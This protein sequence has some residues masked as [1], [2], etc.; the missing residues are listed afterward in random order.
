MHIIEL[1]EKQFKNYSIIHSRKNIYQTVN[2]AKMQEKYGFSHLFLG[3]VD[4][5]DNVVAA[6]LILENVINKKFKY[7]IVPAGYLIDFNDLALVKIFTDLLK[8]YLAKRDY[9]Y[10]RINP[11]LYY[12]LHDSDGVLLEDNSEL[13]ERYKG[14]GYRYLGFDSE[15]FNSNIILKTKSTTKETYKSFKRTTRR[16]INDAL[17]MGITVYKGGI[18]DLETFYNMVRKKSNKS[19]EYYNDY[20]TYFNDDNMKMELYFARIDPQIYIN[21]Y[22]YLLKEETAYNDKLAYTIRAKGNKTTAG[23]INKKMVSDKKLVRYNNEIVKGSNLLRDYPKGL[24]VGTCAIISNNQEIYFMVDGY[25][26]KVKDIH[27]VNLIIWEVIKKYMKDGYRKFNLGKIYSN[28]ENTN[29]KY[30]G[31]FYAKRGFNGKVV[32]YPGDFDLVI[33]NLLYPLF[34]KK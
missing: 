33:N 23:L 29:S 8:E 18:N 19:I 26:R 12:K 4:D 2:Y 32:T 22:R 28:L 13:V 3:L 14:L 17:H 5:S 34:R 20:M 1:T 7:G 25:E 9:I 21:N 30:H 24:I 6:S 31:I 11:L 16:E 27:S 10:L 15:R